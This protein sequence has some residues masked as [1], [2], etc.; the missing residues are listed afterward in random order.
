MEC[1]SWT[2]ASGVCYCYVIAVLDLEIIIISEV[3]EREVLYDTYIY[4]YIIYI[5][6][7]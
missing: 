3:N 2:C 5:I 6:Y 7:M 1:A 4:I